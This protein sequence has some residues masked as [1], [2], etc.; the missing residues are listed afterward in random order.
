M[1]EDKTLQQLVQPR[2][3]LVKKDKL[4]REMNEQNLKQI[5]LLNALYADKRNQSKAMFCFKSMDNLN[6][7]KCKVNK[8][9][10]SQ[11]QKET[12][13][14]IEIEHANRKIQEQA[15]MIKALHDH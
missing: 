14:E 10:I 2:A 7:I 4:L 11:A 13:R 15:Q 5:E 12:W 1:C 8:R 3:E 6:L 9:L